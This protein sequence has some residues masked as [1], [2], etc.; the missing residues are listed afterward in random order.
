MRYLN[1]LLARTILAV[2]LLCGAGQAWAGPIYSVTIDTSTL[3][4]GPAYLGLTFLGLTDA[5]PATAT[6]SNLSG[7]LTGPA[8]VNGTVTGA[9][10]GPLVFS[11]ANGGSDWT[12]AITLGGV[13]SFDVGFAF[14]NGDAG[15]TFAWALFNDVAY[16]GA[17]GDLGTVALQPGSAP[18]EWDWSVLTNASSQSSVNVP[19]PSTVLLMLF[20]GCALAVS[21]RR[22]R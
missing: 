4:T 13:F 20:A 15:T 12:Q 14:D 11:N 22:G 3:G 1:D 18:N 5:A 8:S 6:V 2:S 7:A 16:L 10:P 9:A 17:D 21:A 19:E